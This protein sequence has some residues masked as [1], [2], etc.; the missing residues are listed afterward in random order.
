MYKTRIASD[1]FNMKGL[2]ARTGLTSYSWGLAIIKELVDNALDAV[3]S[4]EEKHIDLIAKDNKFKLFDNGNGLSVGDI[5]QIYDFENYVSKNRHVITASRGKQ[6]NG[7]K[8]I[9]GMCYV[10]K[11]S[12]LWHTNDGII[13]QAVFNADS[14]ADQELAVSFNNV[15]STNRTGVEIDG[16]CYNE[17]FLET[18]IEQYSAC[19]PDVTFNLD[20]ATT[21]KQFKAI[22]V[23]INRTEETSLDFYT[24]KD[25]KRLISVQPPTDTYKSFLKTYF[26]TRTANNSAI[27]S[28]MSDLNLSDKV[29][30]DFDHLK[31]TL[32][33]KPYTLLKQHLLGFENTFEVSIK[34]DSMDI[35]DTTNFPCLVEYTI[36]KLGERQNKTVINCYI[37]NSITYFDGS[38]L[39]FQYNSYKISN[40]KKPV[41]AHDLD[42]LLE[43]FTDYKFDIHIIAPYL[44]FKD[45]GKTQI[46]ISDFIN[47][48]V[49]E[50]R[51][52]L[53]K[54]KK[55][56]NN[57]ANKKPARKILAKMYMTDAFLQASSNGKYAITARQMY[58]KLRELAGRD[59]FD[60]EGKSTYD[61]FTQEWLTEW[62]DENDQYESKVNF[63]ERG[64]FYVDGSQVGLGSANVRTFIDGINSKPDQFVLYGGIQDQIYIKDEFNIKYKYDKALYIEKTGF[65]AVFRAEH[66]DEKYNIF[67][68][69]GQGFAS[70]EARRL[71]YNL[72]K[73]GLKLYCMHDLDVSGV[74]I[75]NSMCQANEKFKHNLEMVDLG[76]TPE[77]VLNYGIVPEQIERIDPDT[78]ATF[79]Y[80]HR[81]FFDNGNTSQRVE[82]NAFST[83]Q[84]LDII[85]K[86]LK[87][88]S[89][90]P[91]VNISN[92]LQIDNKVLREVAFM[93]VLKS[94]YASQLEKINMP[95]DLSAY[96]GKYTMNEAKKAIPEIKERLINQYQQEIIKKIAI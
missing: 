90:L 88:Q 69:S 10:K 12:L 44:K 8:S 33:N 89:D 74:N 19:N 92:S 1:F 49:D 4:Q 29:K 54:E 48:L 57:M 3:E 68:V 93:R 16:I 75:Y 27:K 35:K 71:L 45:F 72:Q 20:F 66:L 80:E 13:L 65:D 5:R 53:N 37:N 42:Q 81:N 60:W 84:L 79:D 14:V 18:I 47:I 55:K 62:L 87:D 36:T 15:E 39:N 91:I 67:I 73:Q 34:A 63:S 76:I 32:K 70:R 38:S 58:Y 64:N 96:D 21:Q 17:E 24:F 61:R 40:T 56:F 85:D 78:L 95:Y 43:S 83:E 41:Y 50:L 86:K 25:F 23:P 77:D 9:I 59:R 7:L 28:K 31:T 46:D 94:K 52:S 26:G 30:N 11:Y 22:A 2:E 82:L 51:K 6:G